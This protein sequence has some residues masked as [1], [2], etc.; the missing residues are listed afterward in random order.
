ML[1]ERLPDNLTR[2]VSPR[3]MKNY[4]KALGWIPVE[5]FNG[6]IAV[7]HAPGV[8]TNQLVIPL[9]ETFDDYADSVS[10]V[11]RKMA[12]F[13]ERSPAEVLDHLLL[14]P[15]DV[16]RF[17]DRSPECETGTINLDEALGLLGGAKKMLLSIAHSV[18]RPTPF[19][20]RL[21]LS[22][23]EYFVRNCRLGQTQR[24]SFIVTIACPL[25]FIPSSVRDPFERKVTDGLVT[26]LQLIIKATD[27][28]SV[29]E[30][31]DQSRYPLFSANF[32]EALCMVR[33]LGERSSLSLDVAWSKA[34]PLRPTTGNGLRSSLQLRPEDFEA[35]QYLAPKLRMLP[36][37]KQ[38]AF[39]GFVDVLRGEAGV[40]DTM[41]GE[42]VFSLVLDSGDS[43]RARADLKP[44]DYKKA[45][46][47][48]MRHEPVYL[49]GFLVMAPRLSRI[50]RVSDL[51]R[52][53]QASES[54]AAE[55]DTSEGGEEV[56]ND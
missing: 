17:R 39:V 29:D 46:D 49:R 10:V 25:E 48:H 14:P 4:A 15:A 26:T 41:S 54:T 42:V 3:A 40:D 30:L 5:R 31:T 36:E 8:Q 28:H 16:L 27:E 47:A 44:S 6:S 18:L 52:L 9:D 51:R 24:G 32:C 50:D 12:E 35:A 13:E 43:I 33:P 22:D 38:E 2:I 37:L 21:S 55:G 7:F 19:H 1:A 45:G 20:P 56:S 53:E 34:L 23:A 11:V